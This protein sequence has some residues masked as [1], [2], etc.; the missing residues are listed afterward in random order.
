MNRQ[1]WKFVGRLC[2]LSALYAA[3]T[4]GLYVY[5]ACC[6]SG[7][8]E[9]S[10]HLKPGTKVLFLGSSQFICGIETNNHCTYEVFAVEESGWQSAYMRLLEL[11]QRG[12]LS[13]VKVCLLE[14]APITIRFLH[15][16]RDAE[17]F[18]KE[19]AVSWRYC[20]CYESDI[21]D[22]ACYSMLHPRRWS[23]QK[24]RAQRPPKRN[25]NYSSRSAEAKRLHEHDI[26]VEV[27]TIREV[28]ASRCALRADLLRLGHNIIE[29]LKRNGIKPVFVSM[30]VLSVYRDKVGESVF[31][32]LA[33]V[34]KSFAQEGVEILEYTS[35]LPD[36]CMVDALHLT[37]EGQ[38]RFTEIISSKISHIVGGGQ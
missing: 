25:F 11:E 15:P 14:F 35:L 20:R 16:N 1:F 31:A 22:I 13:K 33:D 36:D 27:A 37:E 28:F 23:K 24:L 30:P 26:D 38:R 2:L 29:V 12:E 4:V 5:K 7:Q 3:I 6:L 19:L 18:L 10:Y 21:Y 9:T 17:D 34:G 32:E 8:I